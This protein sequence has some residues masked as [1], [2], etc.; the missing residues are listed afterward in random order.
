MRAKLSSL[1]PLNRRTPSPINASCNRASRTCI[2]ASRVGLICVLLVHQEP[3]TLHCLCLCWGDRRQAR[4]P[5]C[6]VLSYFWLSF[7]GVS[8]CERDGTAESC[9]H[10]LVAEYVSS[11]HSLQI[12]RDSVV[13]FIY[14]NTAL[15]VHLL[16]YCRFC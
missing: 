6:S 13:T 11:P 7:G 9:F 4:K 16:G 14:S 2:L 8:G 3:I 1:S 15:I 5:V 10:L 12:S